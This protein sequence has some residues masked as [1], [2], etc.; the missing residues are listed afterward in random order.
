[1]TVRKLQSQAAQHVESGAILGGD[2]LEAMTLE[3]DGRVMTIS[4]DR[5]DHR[6]LFRLP[7]A[8]CW[9]DGEPLPDDL[10][11]N[12]QEIITEI[13]RFWGQDPNFA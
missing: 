12:I 9:D 5:G 1:M 4:V 2:G 11:N 3:R 13:S 7:A 8:L 10:A 6:M